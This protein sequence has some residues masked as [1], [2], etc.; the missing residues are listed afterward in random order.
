[1]RL[2]PSNSSIFHNV[3]TLN[4]PPESNPENFTYRGGARAP[5]P[6]PPYQACDSV[7]ACPVHLGGRIPLAF[8]KSSITSGIA[9]Q[10]HIRTC[11][12]KEILEFPETLTSCTSGEG[13]GPRPWTPPASPTSQFGMQH[14][15]TPCPGHHALAPSNSGIMLVIAIPL[16]T[17]GFPPVTNP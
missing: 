4:Q 3:T 5:G 13:G 9:V 15:A 16:H 12:L 11:L 7:C 2:A 17:L 8:G 1:M 10:L 6:R 14:A